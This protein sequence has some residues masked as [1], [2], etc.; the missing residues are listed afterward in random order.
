MVRS[1]VLACR[2]A[3]RCSPWTA[4][5]LLDPHAPAA[6]YADALARALPGLTLRR[7]VIWP[8]SAEQ[9][10]FDEDWL[11]ACYDALRRGD[12]DSFCF[13]ASRRLRPGMAPLLRLLV[14]GL[15]DRVAAEIERLG[16]V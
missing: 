14:T 7:P 13:L 16:A 3:P 1:A 4:C 5:S 6:A 2:A 15:S 12:E 9:R 8:A 10:T 11:V